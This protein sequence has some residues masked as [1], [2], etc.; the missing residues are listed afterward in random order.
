MKAILP[1]RVMS[2]GK[3]TICHSGNEIWNV[4]AETTLIEI[5][6]VQSIS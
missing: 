3:S 2:V 6:I 5:A 1:K 4:I